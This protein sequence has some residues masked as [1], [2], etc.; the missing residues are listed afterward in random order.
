[1]M[2]TGRVKSI[3]NTPGKKNPAKV[4]IDTKKSQAKRKSV[5]F[6]GNKGQIQRFSM[7]KSSHQ[8]L[9]QSDMKSSNSTTNVLEGRTS[10]YE[11]EE[12]VK[13]AGVS[14]IVG[15]KAE[16]K[17]VDSHEEDSAVLLSKLDEIKIN[18]SSYST[19]LNPSS[20]K[21]CVAKSA[22]ASQLIKSRRVSLVPSSDP[23][24]TSRSHNKQ[25][26]QA[27]VKVVVRVRPPSKLETVIT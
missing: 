5:D 14:P 16:S 11:E 25:V 10:A 2:K 15:H 20:E 19:T 23:N 8:K 3:L 1:M 21:K 13:K 22:D 4:V 17:T 9:I 27:N 12:T 18:I 24:R 6:T 26:H 7:N